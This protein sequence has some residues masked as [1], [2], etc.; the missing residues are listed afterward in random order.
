MA[1]NTKQNIWVVVS[2]LVGITVAAL[3]TLYYSGVLFGGMFEGEDKG[4]QNVTFTDA[5][6][7]CKRKTRDMYKSNIK[8]LVV[9]NHSSRYEQNRFLYLI[10]LKMDLYNPKQNRTILHYVNC[11]VKSSNGQVAKYETFENKEAKTKAGR[12]DDTNLFGW[13]K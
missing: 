3:V 5:V 1:K 8:L 7:A 13:P 6:I 2:S 10:F 9:D 12:K 4:Y 11:F